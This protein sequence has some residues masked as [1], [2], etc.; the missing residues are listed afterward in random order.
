MTIIEHK[1]VVTLNCT[2]CSK[3]ETFTVNRLHDLDNLV[4]SDWVK[5]NDEYD[6]S[7]NCI[8]VSI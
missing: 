2:F 3:S 8:K 6:Y 1:F 4:T 5:D 7:H